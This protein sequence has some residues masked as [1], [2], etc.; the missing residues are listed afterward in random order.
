[1]HATLR[2]VSPE[3]VHGDVFCLRQTF[4]QRRGEEEGLPG[5][6]G[7]DPSPTWLLSSQ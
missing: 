2:E 4:P 6:H 5:I 1:M 7:P 3:G